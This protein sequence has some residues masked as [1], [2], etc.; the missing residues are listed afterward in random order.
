MPA[1]EG[2]VFKQPFDDRKEKSPTHIEV[3][4]VAFSYKSRPHAKVLEGV[5]ADVNQCYH[6]QFT[7][8]SR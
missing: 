7:P 6:T 2:I 5:I 1:V 8:R 3:Q 4:N